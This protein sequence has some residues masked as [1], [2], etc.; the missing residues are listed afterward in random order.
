MLG[1][2]ALAYVARFSVS[3]GKLENYLCRKLRER[4]W[5]GEGEPP[6]AAIIARFISAGY[7]D[8][9]AW[10]NAKSGGLLRKGYGERRISQALSAAGIDTELRRNVRVSDAEARRSAL[11]MARKRSLG[12]F[13]R[14]MPDRAQRERQVAAMLRAGH[15]LDSA[16]RL[17]DAA[18]IEDAEEWAAEAQDR[19]TP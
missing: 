12:P 15:P 4:G 17:V 7:V 1:E 8:D 11:T 9:A 2:L 14:E 18:S 5:D 6:V 10:A 16:R 3:T 19:E 13:G